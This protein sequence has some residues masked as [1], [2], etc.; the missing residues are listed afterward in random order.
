MNISEHELEIP[1]YQLVG[2]LGVE[3]KVPQGGSNLERRAQK[4]AASLGL[5]VAWS[6]SS[7]PPLYYDYYGDFNV[8]NGRRQLQNTDEVVNYT[9]EALQKLKI[10]DQNFYPTEAE[11][12]VGGVFQ[13]LISALADPSHFLYKEL[14]LKRMPLNLK[15]VAAM[16]VAAAH[17]IEA[18]RMNGEKPRIANILTTNHTADETYFPYLNIAKTHKV[19]LTNKIDEVTQR[20]P[21]GLV[22]SHSFPSGLSRSGRPS[23]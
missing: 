8:V 14:R 18:L 9:N 7:L 3:V 19:D 20:I 12:F 11:L 23:R 1:P 5:L 13:G 22:P 15:A 21:A 10:P 4:D 6:L 2:K 16:G 17:D